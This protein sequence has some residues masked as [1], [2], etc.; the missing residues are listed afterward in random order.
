MK[1]GIMTFHWAANHGAVLQTYS[2]AKYLMDNY[3]IEVE[4][5]NYYPRNLEISFYNAIR[6]L[7]PWAVFRKFKELK[8]E[9]AIKPFRL[10]LPLTYRFYTN[11]ELNEAKFDYDIVFV[12]SDQIWNPYFLMNGENKITP[13]YYLDFINGKTRKIA[14]SASFGCNNFPNECKSIVLPLLNQF[15]AIS[16]RE[17]TGLDILNSMGISNGSLTADPTALI[18]REEYLKKTEGTES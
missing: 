15:Y 14:I 3:G 2:L 12:G 4:I 16:V 11:E 8:K 13:T 9:R 1:V 7:K 17:K 18:T 10:K 5:I 6:V